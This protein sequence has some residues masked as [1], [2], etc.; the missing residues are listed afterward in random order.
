M[1][2]RAGSTVRLMGVPR[3]SSA[4]WPSRTPWWSKIRY[5]GG[6]CRLIRSGLRR[7]DLAV[8]HHLSD[9]GKRWWAGHQQHQLMLQGHRHQG[10]RHAAGPHEGVNALKRLPWAAALAYQRGDLTGRGLRARTRS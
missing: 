2:R 1:L 9:E 3:R 7:V 8:T 10:R 5:G 4:R 6:K